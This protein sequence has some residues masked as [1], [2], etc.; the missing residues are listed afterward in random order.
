MGSGTKQI[1]VPLQPRPLTLMVKGL[2][3]GKRQTSFSAVRTKRIKKVLEQCLTHSQCPQYSA[4]MWNILIL[5]ISCMTL[6]TFT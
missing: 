2:S 3:A 5:H 6:G 4:G 1:L